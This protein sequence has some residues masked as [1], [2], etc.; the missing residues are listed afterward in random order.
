VTRRL[1]LL[2]T[3]A[4]ALAFV[5]AIAVLRRPAPPRAPHRFALGSGPTIALLHGPGGGTEDW[6]PT[7][8]LLA[9]SYR[10]VL[11]ELPGHGLAPLPEPLTLERAAQALHVTLEAESKEPVVL[12]GHGAAGLV[13]ALEAAEHPDRVRALVLIETALRPQTD[14]EELREQLAGIHLDYPRVVRRIY[15]GY[16]RDSAQGEMLHA[17]AARMAPASLGPWLSLGLLADVS[18]RMRHLRPPL[19][20]IFSERLWPV[21]RSWPEVAAP[22]GYPDTPNARSAR[23]EGCGHFPMLDRPEE[24]ARLI[25]HFAEVSSREPVAAR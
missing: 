20:A 18:L 22:L 8:R 12:V 23:I 25:Q 10:V 11:I 21:E 1:L 2:I 6:L 16:G 7:A 13:A 14:G 5:I 9:K 4:A 19:L 24:I 17:R 15:S 3:V